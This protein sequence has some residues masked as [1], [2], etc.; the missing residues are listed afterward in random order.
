MII[1]LPIVVCGKKIGHDSTRNIITITND[2]GDIVRIPEL[3]EEDVIKIEKSRLNTKLHE[4]HTDDITIFF[5]KISRYWMQKN[6]PLRNEAIK[7]C[8]RITGYDKYVLLR[9]YLLF[10]QVH[11]TRSELYD[12]LEAELGDIW[13]LDEWIPVE[14]CLIH[15]QPRGLVT[16]IL[17]GNIPLSSLLGMFRALIVKNNTVCKLAKKDPITALYFALSFIELE[18]DHPITKSLSVVYWDRDSWQGD[19]LLEASDVV[20]VW[21]GE[22]AVRQVKKKIKPGTKLL[23]FG[24]KRSIS[25]IDLSNKEELDSLEDIAH[26]TAHDFS[27]YNQ[28]ACFNSQEMFLIADDDMY[29]KFLEELKKALNFNLEKFPKNDILDDNKGHTYMK[30][31]EHR[32]IGDRVISTESHDWTIIVTNEKKRMNNHPLNR[33][34]VI[35]RISKLE[36][37]LDY[38]DKY[39]QTTVIYPWKLN[40]QLRD[41]LTI[42][43][44]DRIAGLGMAPQPRAGAPHDGMRIYAELIRW[45]VVERDLDYKSK[46]YDNSKDSFVH[47]LFKSKW[48]YWE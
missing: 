6:N 22:E 27:L 33:A 39:T 24:P 42:R 34:V 37:V 32:F 20:S 40:V 46:Y 3:N 11:V 45:V 15:A 4:T 13:Y 1:D 16:N 5:Q 23:E 25:V 12:Q 44:V 8:S 43:G 31:L 47:N 18:P 28:E 10:S 21:G 9:D 38:V 14:A 7:F 35:H 17:V 29:E 36:E 19:R 26:R 2:N 48:E 30:R 41:Q